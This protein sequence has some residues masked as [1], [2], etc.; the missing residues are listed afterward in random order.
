MRSKGEKGDG[1]RWSSINHII[2]FFNV[3][4]YSPDGK[5]MVV[6]K[7]VMQFDERRIRDESK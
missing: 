5:V 1:Y 2:G 4:C 7:I 3:F 6:N